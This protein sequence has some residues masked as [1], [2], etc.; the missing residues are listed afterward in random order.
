MSTPQYIIVDLRDVML[1]F[2]R[3]RGL[4]A[5][6]RVVPLSEIIQ[7]IL[8]SPIYDDTNQYLWD[9]ISDRIQGTDIDYDAMAFFFETIMQNLDAC[10]RQRAMRIETELY[11]F[12]NWVGSTSVIMKRDLD[13]ENNYQM[14][15][16]PGDIEQI[17]QRHLATGSPL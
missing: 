15:F 12:E 7:C 14:L 6:Y 2:S 5:L 4:Q 1:E 11:L 10:V 3:Y 13:L 16:S 17:R 8:A 9:H